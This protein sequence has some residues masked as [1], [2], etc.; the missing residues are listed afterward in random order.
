M[1]LRPA[2]PS[3]TLGKNPYSDV[4]TCTPAG[5]DIRNLDPCEIQLRERANSSC[6]DA[7][8]EE[9]KDVVEAEKTDGSQNIWYEFWFV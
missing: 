5:V 8:F 6:Y 1:H 2:K 7:S 9:T 3:Q 4:L